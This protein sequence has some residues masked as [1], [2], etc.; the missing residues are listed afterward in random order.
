MVNQ[1]GPLIQRTYEAA[2]EH[3]TRS[4]GTATKDPTAYRPRPQELP[5]VPPE[6]IE[7]LHCLSTFPTRGPLLKYNLFSSLAANLAQR[8][9]PV[10]KTMQHF[11]FKNENNEKNHGNSAANLP[12]RY[13]F[14]KIAKQHK[15]GPEPHQTKTTKIHGIASRHDRVSPP[16]LRNMHKR[17]NSLWPKQINEITINIDSA[18]QWA[19]KMGR[20]C[21]RI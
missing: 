19:S 15:T 9:G 10:C 2:K 8:L 12:S 21:R 18:S 17:I 1:R 6:L 20:L 5:I 14:A 4:K 16:C 3:A 11:G 13:A 7:L